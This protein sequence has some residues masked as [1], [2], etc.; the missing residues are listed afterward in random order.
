M[1]SADVQEGTLFNKEWFDKYY[2]LL[3][4]VLANSAEQ[5]EI[6]I[7][8]LLTERLGRTPTTYDLK[9]CTCIFDARKN[10]F[11]N[12]DVKVYLFMYDNE[13]LGYIRKGGYKENYETKFIPYE[14]KA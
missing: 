14:Q 8:R 6:L 7:R 2:E 10:E 12:P 5:E 11:M 4:K 13:P 1:K 9:L 3:G